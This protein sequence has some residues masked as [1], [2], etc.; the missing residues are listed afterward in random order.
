MPSRLLIQAVREKDA[1]NLAL[2]LAHGIGLDVN[3]GSP[4]NPLVLAIRNHDTACATLLL[5]QPTIDVNAVY[6]DEYTL[7]Q[8]CMEYN[9]EA[10]FAALV[11]HPDTNFARCDTHGNTALH[12]AVCQDTGYYMTQLLPKMQTYKT[13]TNTRGKT[14]AEEAIELGHYANFSLMALTDAV[15]LRACFQTAVASRQ[16]SAA[17]LLVEQYPQ[18]FRPAD[19]DRKLFH[20]LTVAKAPMFHTDTLRLLDLLLSLGLDINQRDSQHDHISFAARAIYANLTQLAL[21]LI[22]HPEYLVSTDMVTAAI[23]TH[24][25]PVFTALLAVPGVSWDVPADEIPPLMALATLDNADDSARTMYHLL[26]QSKI[27]VDWNVWTA[28]GMT[29]YLMAYGDKV[30]RRR[31]LQQMAIKS[32]NFWCPRLHLALG[33]HYQQKVICTLLA[34]GRQARQ[35]RRLPDEL[36]QHIFSFWSCL[37]V[38]RAGVRT[39]LR[40]VRWEVGQV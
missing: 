36:W 3:E 4:A 2:L 13:W 19:M 33:Q 20:Y 40:R 1:T 11:A 30:W 29:P 32:D 38:R 22:G 34:A 26:V 12:Y 7:L 8:V 10:I 39:C 16:A 25:I 5:Q 31:I 24:N 21:T 15:S 14:A 23:E 18:C 28:G 35:Q 9:E 27:P 17:Q 6:S 37:R